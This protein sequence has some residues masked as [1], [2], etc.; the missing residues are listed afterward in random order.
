MVCLVNNVPGGLHR[1]DTVKQLQEV[2]DLMQSSTSKW[3][4]GVG[5]HPIRSYGEHCQ[6]GRGVSC[7][8]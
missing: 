3:K 8:I 6:A 1:Q 4:I 7:G 2:Q 5:H